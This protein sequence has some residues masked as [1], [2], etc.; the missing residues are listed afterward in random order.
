MR[1]F[2]CD[3]CGADTTGTHWE[4]TVGTTHDYDLCPS[5]KDYLRRVLDQQLWKGLKLGVS[6]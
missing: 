3:A 5:C 1:Q 4:V 6:L 2:I